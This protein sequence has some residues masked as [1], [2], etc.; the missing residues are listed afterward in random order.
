MFFALALGIL[1]FDTRNNA[2]HCEIFLFVVSKKK[3]E[4]TFIA[5]VSVAKT[6]TMTNR[7]GGKLFN[8]LYANGL[9]DCPC[10]FEIY[11]SDVE[12]YGLSEDSYE[13]LFRFL[14]IHIQ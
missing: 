13:S 14:H 11:C 4:I 5:I 9:S 8:E 7:D 6:S 3:K 12:I 2:G 1:I 10:D